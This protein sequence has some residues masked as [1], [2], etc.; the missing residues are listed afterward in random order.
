MEREVLWRMAP[1]IIW[2]LRF[3]LPHHSGPAAGVA[4]AARALPLRPYRRPQPAAADPLRGPR[5]R[6]GRQAAGCRNRYNRRLSIPIAGSTTR[7][8][9][10]STA[11]DAAERGA[12]I[13]HPHARGRDPRRPTVSGTLTVEDT[14]RCARSDRHAR[15]RSST[16]AGPWVADVLTRPVPASNA[17]AKV[18][19]VQ[20]THIVVRR[21]FAHDRAYFFQNA[22]GRIIF[23]I[24][25][26]H[27]FTLIGTTD[28]DYRRRSGRRKAS[29]GGDRLPL[30]LRP[31][32]IFAQP[33]DARR[34][35]LDLFRRASALRRR[36]HEAQAATRDY[37]LELDAPGGGAPLLSIFGGK[38][39]TYRR[40]AEAALRQ[41][42]RR[43]C[44]APGQERLDRGCAAARRRLPGRRLRGA[45]RGL[46]RQLSVP[47]RRR[48]AD[49]LARA[50]G[51]RAT[52]L[53]RRCAIA[54]RS[55]PSPSAPT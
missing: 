37:V 6:R 53:A 29:A 38:I 20:G 14:R 35:G 34:R 42:R 10:C 40:L 50:Y 46:I 17:P 11:R 24:P 33:I 22:D 3:V 47:G 26:E 25:Y 5:A 19:L 4:A 49:R 55:R 13:R 41:A 12:D 39:T 30:R 45:R 51:T 44:A 7:A 21:L 27:D 28:R 43:I 31:A 2:P 52:R 1:H 54:G 23:A 15:A 36:R 8:S 16:P 18:R 9:S 32:N 48:H